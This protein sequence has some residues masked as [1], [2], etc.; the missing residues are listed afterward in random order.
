M[1]KRAPFVALSATFMDDPAV[2]E[3]GERAAW[4]FLAMMLD[5]R[6]QRTDGVVPA[7]RLDRLGVP[8]WRPRLAKLV[9]VG[10][11]EKDGTDWRLPAYLK[12]NPGESE[13]QRKQH[14][15]RVDVCRRHHEQP[16]D[17]DA[18]ADSAEWLDLHGT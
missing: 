18:C 4:L 12:W 15:G 5:C 2:V 6:L 9:D 14:R 11:V 17:R 10:L 1:R 13:Y 7:H 3:A 16:C 8:A